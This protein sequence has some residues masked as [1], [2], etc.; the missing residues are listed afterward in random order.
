MSGSCLCLGV[1]GVSGV[2]CTGDSELLELVTAQSSSEPE[3][4]TD[5][6]GLREAAD[7]SALC[8]LPRLDQSEAAWRSRDLCVDQSEAGGDQEAAPVQQARHHPR[9]P[10]AGG[11][12]P[13]LP[14]GAGALPQETL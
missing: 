10:E 13:R 14:G 6:G 9:H 12:R 11:V 3:P 1:S 8:S 5:Q 7:Q 2:H 4:E